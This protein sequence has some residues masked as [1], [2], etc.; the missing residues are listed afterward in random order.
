MG[1]LQK[2]PEMEKAENLVVFSHPKSGVI[3]ANNFHK[4]GLVGTI[5]VLLIV[6]FNL[7]TPRYPILA[8]ILS[9]LPL[10]ASLIVEIVLSKFAYKISFDL[11]KN[12][13]TFFMF[14]NKGSIKLNIKQ[15]EKVYLNAY[16]TFVFDD[17]K[18]RYND[19]VNK[20]LVNILEEFTIISWGFLGKILHKWW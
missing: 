19:V 10:F 7:V 17:M 2:K 13:I 11:D 5:I 12:E 1:N 16:I 4:F 15:I 14:R 8:Y 20:K 3:I 9:F 6:Y 18:I